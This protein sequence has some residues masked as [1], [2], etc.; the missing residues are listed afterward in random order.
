MAG[1][2]IE[3]DYL[4]DAVVDVSAGWG[5]GVNGLNV[6][7]CA[8]H[9][10]QIRLEIRTPLAWTRQPVVVFRRAEPTRRYQV[11]LQRGRGRQLERGRFGE[12]DSA[13]TCRE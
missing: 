12:G 5:V 9:G 7:R 11:L 6:V 2:E 3:E 8:I 4:R 13:V 1:I 10:S